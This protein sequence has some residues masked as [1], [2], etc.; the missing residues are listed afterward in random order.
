M[1]NR[2]EEMEMGKPKLVTPISYIASECCTVDSMDVHGHRSATS[3]HHHQLL[4]CSFVRLFRFSIS[5][6]FVPGFATTQRHGDTISLGDLVPLAII[7]H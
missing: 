3:I 2:N 7:G 6:S 5:I 1:G 4:Y